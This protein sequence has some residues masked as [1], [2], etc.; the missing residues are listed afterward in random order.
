MRCGGER[1]SN[2]LGAELLFLSSHQ[3]AWDAVSATELRALVGGLSTLYNST[4]YARTSH[5]RV[6]AQAS[7]LLAPVCSGRC[8]LTE[9][10]ER[11]CVCMMWW[12]SEHLERGERVATIALREA[13]SSGR[14]GSSRHAQQPRPSS[15]ARERAPTMC[16]RG[17]AQDVPCWDLD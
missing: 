16:P 2:A 9:P 10:T 5:R 12:C 13:D 8:A 3:R 1:D 6:V 4:H 17:W 14:A 15:G 11:H 7:P